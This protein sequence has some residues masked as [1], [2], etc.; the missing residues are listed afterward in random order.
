MCATMSNLSSYP[1]VIESL[2]VFFD[3]FDAI[4]SSQRAAFSVCF[5]DWNA[6]SQAF[7]EG[8]T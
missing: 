2:L 3:P 6:V 7:T 1:V 4:G 8:R 5:T